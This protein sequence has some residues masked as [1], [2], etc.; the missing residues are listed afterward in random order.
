MIEQTGCDAVMIGRAASYNPWIF[1]QI[2]EFLTTGAYWQPTQ[3]DRY[4]IMKQYFQMLEE[5]QW[6]EAV[7]KMKQFTGYFT[8]G[9]RNG[10]R[11]RALI[12]HQHETGRIIA[13]VDRFFEEELAV[14]AA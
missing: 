7:G 8:H 12:Y 5:T 10:S 1:R 9:V 4:R 3:E 11:L 14:A 6:P 13:E 2:S